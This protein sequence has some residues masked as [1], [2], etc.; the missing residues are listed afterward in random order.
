MDGSW[1]HYAKWN[2]SDRER[3]ISYDFTYMW[4]LKNKQPKKSSYIQR[5]DWLSQMGIGDQRGQT[6]SYKINKSQG[7]NVQHGT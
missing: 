1:G 4:N 7:C 2:K 3:Q 5:T 6:S